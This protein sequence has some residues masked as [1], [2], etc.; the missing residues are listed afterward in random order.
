M[1]RPV[2]LASVAI[3]AL[4]VAAFAA[5]NPIPVTAAVTGQAEISFQYERT[6]LTIPH[7]VIQIREDGTGSYQ[8]DEVSQTKASMQQSAGRHIDRTITLTPAMTTKIFKTARE[9]DLFNIACASSMK[10]IADTGTKTLRYEGADGKGSCVY[11]Y[12]ENKNIT[13]LTDVFVAIAFTLDEGRKLDFLHR[14]DR[15]G[16]DAEMASL[17]HEVQQGRALE[18]GTISSTLTAIASD[19]ALIQRVRLQAAKM[20]EMSKGND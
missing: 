19:P 4:S 13:M 16:L 12:S 11:N 2:W 14:F 5:I 9:L 10:N 15:L 20:L 7:F 8:A 18:L 6:G 17:T 3:A 1:R